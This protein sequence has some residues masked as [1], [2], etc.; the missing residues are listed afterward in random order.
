VN[1]L[2]GGLLLAGSFY[3]LG[4]S[5]L[6]PS[7]Q[8]AWSAVTGAGMGVIVALA[9]AVFL[10]P[11]LARRRTELV[12]TNKRLI[13]KFGL[14]STQSIE[15]RLEKIESVRVGQSL[16]GRMLNY[17]DIVVTGTGSTFDPIRNIASPLAFRTALNQA[18]DP[19]APSEAS[20][21]HFGGVTH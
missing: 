5:L 13:A 11:L 8:Y 20:A 18:M 3:L 14:L 1:F 4:K 6:G 16:I 19:R 21:L 9:L 15:I 10:W 7:N 17:G 12:I 2:I